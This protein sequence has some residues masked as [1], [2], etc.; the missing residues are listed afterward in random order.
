MFSSVVNERVWF[1]FYFNSFY[2]CIFVKDIKK[3]GVVHVHLIA[4]IM[5]EV[6]Y[7]MKRSELKI[8]KEFCTVIVFVASNRHIRR[9]C[10]GNL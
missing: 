3:Q 9:F 1:R 5:K 7:S 8:L 6:Y 10:C 2:R 4:N